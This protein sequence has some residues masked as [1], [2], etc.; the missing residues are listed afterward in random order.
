MIIKLSLMSYWCFSGC[1]DSNILL[2][3][4]ADTSGHVEFEMCKNYCWCYSYFSFF[5]PDLYV[6][7]PIL[8]W[9]FLAGVVWELCHPRKKLVPSYEDTPCVK[10]AHKQNIKTVRH[11]DM[12]SLSQPHDPQMCTEPDLNPSDALLLL[13]SGEWPTLTGGQ[14]GSILNWH[15]IIWQTLDTPGRNSGIICKHEDCIQTV[16]QGYQ[17]LEQKQSRVATLAGKFTK[18]TVDVCSSLSKQMLW[19]TQSEVTWPS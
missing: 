16:C 6:T 12:F 3:S 19:I 18:C 10:K 5:C 1:W 7:I 4:S 11:P 15:P 14:D 9:T 17:D 8:T 13:V 2:F